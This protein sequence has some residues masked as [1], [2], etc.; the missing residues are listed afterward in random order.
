MVCRW[1][2]AELVVPLIATVCRKRPIRL[3]IASPSEDPRT[4]P[5]PAPTSIRSR[6]SG[7]L[8]VVE[9]SPAP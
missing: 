7:R 1:F 8:N 3:P 5:V 4:L 6:A 9:P 2:G